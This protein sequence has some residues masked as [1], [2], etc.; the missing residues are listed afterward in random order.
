MS[1]FLGSQEFLFF[2][3]PERE[4]NKHIHIVCVCVGGSNILSF[5]VV[6]IL[7]T[8]CKRANHVGRMLLLKSVLMLRCY[9]H[10]HAM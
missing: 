7:S 5:I 2:L 8:N 10:L 6:R 9:S 4:E 1:A 3:S